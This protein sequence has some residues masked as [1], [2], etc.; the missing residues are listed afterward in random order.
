MLVTMPVPV[1][2]QLVHAH[3]PDVGIADVA[4]HTDAALEAS[5]IRVPR[6]EIAIALGSRGIAGLPEVA[7]RVVAWVRASGGEPFVV[8]AMGSHGGATGPGQR[9]VLE[10]Y[11]LGEA[12]LGCEIRSAMDVVTLTRGD[13][14]VPVVM[15]AHAAGAAAT[16]VINRVK[17]HTDFHGL[18]ESGLMKMLA[19]GLGKR[20]QA[21]ALH[22]FGVRGLRDLMPQVARQVLAAG[23][24]L[25]GVGVVESPLGAP[26]RIDVVAAPDIPAREQELL[27]VARASM[28][29]LLVDA[30][31][32][33]LVDQMGKDIS[34]CGMDTNV[35]GRLMIRGEA[36]PVW[37][38]VAMIGCHRLTPA[39]HG[40]ACGLGLADVV[41][42][43]FVDSIDWDAT[44]TNIVTSGF[45]LRGKMPVVA[46]DARHVWDLCLRGATVRDALAVRAMRV[47]DT[48]HPHRAWVSE[49]VAAELAARTDVEIVARGLALHDQAGALVA[50]AR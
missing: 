15:D 1:P 27:A 26:C 47:V 30:L 6:G 45:L 17:P 2:F 28:P 24:V 46:D 18:F 21:E 34:G 3:L 33:L 19:I 37:P 35:I 36:D 11:R 14:P 23:N 48:R 4:A 44:R 50:F 10:G 40:N 41:P 29:R 38:D 25:V 5:G 8:P 9:E 39:S 42:Q 20:V 43:S 13:S 49:A 22:A 12:E 32:V 31:D 7:R 16:I